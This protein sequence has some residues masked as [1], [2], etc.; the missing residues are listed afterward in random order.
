MVAKAIGSVALVRPGCEVWSKTRTYSSHGEVFPVGGI[1]LYDS[2]KR[3]AETG[4]IE[5]SFLVVDLTRHPVWR[6]RA[7]LTELDVD[8]TT[9]Q[10]VDVSRLV[11]LW[12]TLAGELAY[13]APYRQRRGPAT[14]EEA[15]LAEA[16]LTLI[17]LV[18]GPDGLLH[19]VLEAPQPAKPVDP[20]PTAPVAVSALVD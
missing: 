16:V 4:E 10:S 1:V 20:L 17:Q 5:R 14:A 8:P 6:H 19:G 15:H 7:W 2:T 13:K 11:R 3:D 9:A 18:F 12:R